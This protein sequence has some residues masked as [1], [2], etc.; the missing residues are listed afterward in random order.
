MFDKNKNKIANDDSDSN[1]G[2]MENIINISRRLWLPF[3]IFLILILSGIII[4][5][6]IN[7]QA[8]NNLGEP[9]GNNNEEQPGIL[10]GI[11]KL[12]VNSGNGSSNLGTSTDDLKAEFLSFGQFYAKDNNEIKSAILKYD[13][14][15]DVKTDVSNYHYIYR[16]LNLDNYIAGLN[17]NGFM[18]IDNPYKKEA[19]DFYSLFGSLTGNDMPILI[20]DDFLI[21]N[22]HNIIK[23][24]FKDIEKDVFYN[25]IWD[26]NKNF[27]TIA[28][29]RYKKKLSEIGIVNDPVLEGERLEA[30]FFAVALELL[31]PADKQINSN[32]N[33]VDETKFKE[34]EV[35]KYTIT[36]PD[37]LINNVAKEVDL[38][39]KANSKGK[40]PNFLYIMDYN[41]FKVPDE[42]KASAKLNNYYLASKWMNTVFPLHYQSINCPDCLLDKDDWLINMV[43]AS[44]IAEDFSNNQDFKNQWA[45]I[46]KIISFFSGLRYDFTYLHYNEILSNL[47]GDGYSVEDIFSNNNP[48]REANIKKIQDESAKYNFSD[49]EGSYSRNDISQKPIIGLRMLS[50]SYW[51]NDYLFGQLVYPQVTNYIGEK[52][53]VLNPT[54]CKIRPTDSNFNRCRGL[55]TDIVNLIYSPKVEDEAYLENTLYEHYDEQI[56]R[57]KQSINNFN[58]NSW[59]NNIYWSTLNILKFSLEKDAD[60]PS[61]SRSNAWEKENI[62]TAMGAWV[63]LQLPVDKFSLKPLNNNSTGFNASLVCNKYNYI[64]PSLE[65]VKE[66]RANGKMLHN[67]FIALGIT[68]EVSSV[69]HYLDEF[70]KTYAIIEKI[71]SKE[72]KNEALNE[73]DCKDMDEIINKYSVERSQKQSISIN[74]KNTKQ[75]MVKSVNGVKLLIVINRYDDDKNLIFGPIFDYQE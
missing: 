18:I 1:A 62:N 59:H 57:Q 16:K 74:L 31:K 32:I 41:Q 24:A 2:G 40:S 8:N 4:Y 60:A 23:Q 67:M 56:A 65:L 42:Y 69:A 64:E 17:K 48:D 25:N 9:G 39:R 30:E 47:F 61:F 44:Y 3:F 71:I 29:T 54:A 21:Y 11:D 51:P 45:K 7:N 36:I 49:I 28:D 12:P 75:N 38:I 20:T 35:D 70:D 52:I 53:G 33:L 27:F 26:I 22:Y 14:P 34:Q 66:L 58:V 5:A 6:I 13:L 68:E 73:Q 63:N 43:A 46:Y 15:L 55:G 19:N 10:G 50:E 72:L 37:Y